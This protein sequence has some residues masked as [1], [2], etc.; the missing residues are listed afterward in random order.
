MLLRICVCVC[1]HQNYRTE[2]LSTQRKQSQ[3][4]N[5]KNCSGER[6][7]PDFIMKGTTQENRELVLQSRNSSVVGRLQIIQGKITRHPE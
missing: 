2:S 1:A 6:K 7:S 3:T 4:R 5:T